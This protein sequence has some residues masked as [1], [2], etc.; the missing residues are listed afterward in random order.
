M[1]SIRCNNKVTCLVFLT[2]SSSIRLG[3]NNSGLTWVYFAPIVSKSLFIP[4]SRGLCSGL[5]ENSKAPSPLRSPYREVYQ[6]RNMKA[7]GPLA[8]LVLAGNLDIINGHVLSDRLCSFLPIQI[9]KRP[10]QFAH[11]CFFNLFGKE[12]KMVGAD[13]T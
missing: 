11:R 3:I 13:E 10:I 2:L 9:C 7:T 5:S 8:Y 1:S 12:V 6:I 4:S